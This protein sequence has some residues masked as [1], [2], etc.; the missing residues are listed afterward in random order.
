MVSFADQLIVVGF[1]TMVEQYCGKT[2]LEVELQLSGRQGRSAPHKWRELSKRF[3]I[4]GI[5]LTSCRG[6]EVVNECRILNNKIKHVG[7]VDAEMAKFDRYKELYGHDLNRISIDTQQY[8]NSVH[9]FIGAVIEGSSELLI[10]KGK[11]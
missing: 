3:D 4:V 5:R 9:T 6:Y 1:W 8:A 11:M 7:S 2:L 10:G